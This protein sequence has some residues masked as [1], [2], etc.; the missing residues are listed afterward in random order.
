MHRHR[1]I[2]TGKVIEEI[3]IDIFLHILFSLL[4]LLNKAKEAELGSLI[5]VPQLRGSGGL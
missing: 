3:Y 5:P 1:H 4:F 2:D